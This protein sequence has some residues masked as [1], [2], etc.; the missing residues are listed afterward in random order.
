MPR[1]RADAPEACPSEEQPPR[2]PYQ[3]DWMPVTPP[4]PDQCPRCHGFVLTQ[5]DETKCLNCAWYLTPEPLPQEPDM[6]KYGAMLPS[7]VEV[8]R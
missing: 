3:A 5:Y 4:I 2:P 6:M 8:R 1:T 7:V